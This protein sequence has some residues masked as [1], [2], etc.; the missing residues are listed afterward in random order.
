[1]PV[2]DAGDDGEAANDAAGPGLIAQAKAAVSTHTGLA[3]DAAIGALQRQRTRFA[4]APEA[5]AEV[6]PVVEDVPP[7]SK[8]RR[9]FR[10][11]LLATVMLLV[12]ALVGGWLSFNVF[13]QKIER[14]GRL[15]A[16]QAD[17]AAEFR[18]DADRAERA[19]DEAKAELRD[20]KRELAEV[21]KN[22]EDAKTRLAEVEG[23]TLMYGSNRANAPRPARSPYTSSRDNAA[24][25]QSAE[26]EL[27]SAQDLSRCLSLSK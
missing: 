20:V 16:D 9:F 26:C 12:G 2:E 23:R 21:T 13:A 6:A 14:Q 8:A 18:D 24:R 22:Y 10:Y 4:P 19:R 17:E 3:F 11:L 5:D 7:P 27:S 1:M 15:I 25:G